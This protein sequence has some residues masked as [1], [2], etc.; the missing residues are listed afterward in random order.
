MPRRDSEAGFTLIELSIAVLLIGILMAGVF[1]VLSVSLE[2]RA[3]GD[4]STELQQTAR[5][6]VDLMVRE[7]QYAKNINEVKATSIT[8]ETE[9]FLPKKTITYLLVTENGIGVLK[10]DQNDG[11]SPQ[12]VTGGGTAVNVSVSALEFK[13]LKTDGAGNT[14]TV[15]I[16]FTVTD[17]AVTDAAKRPSYTLRTAV[18]GMN[19]PTLLY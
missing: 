8:F 16:T 15:G 10:R 18:T 19:N 13:K 6:A 14:L 7:L 1:G 5:Y 4:R 17:L 12:P 9:Q 11:S 2:S 3:R